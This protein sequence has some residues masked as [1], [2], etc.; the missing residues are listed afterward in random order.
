MR[1]YDKIM[2]APGK[3]VDQV[4]AGSF[5][6]IAKEMKD[7]QCFIIEPDLAV[8]CEEVC[9][10][11]PSS[12]LSALSHTRVP[13]PKTWLEWQPINR[14]LLSHQNDKPTP[15]R[16][17][18][19]IM[20]D[21]QGSRGT[22]MYFWEHSFKDELPE[23]ID[24]SS[25]LTLDPF[26]IIFDWSGTTKEPVMAQ[27]ARSIGIEIAETVWRDKYGGKGRESY[28]SSLQ[29]SRRWKNLAH[30]E[31]EVES[32]IELDKSAGIIPLIQCRPL[33]ESPIGKDLMPGGPMHDNFMEDLSGE[34][35]YTQALV[36]MLNT[37]NSVIQHTKEDLS[38]LNKARAKHRKP[39]FKEFTITN[40][41]LNKVHRKLESAAGISREVARKHLVRGHFK[42]RSSGVYWWSSHIRGI[43]DQQIKR[44]EYKVGL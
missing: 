30:Y 17:G 31:Q 35:A 18:C 42:L 23:I 2:A 6:N 41:R 16:M 1:L 27:Y 29:N 32:Y 13:Y 36:L 43:K 25:N 3:A 14:T 21:E 40:L 9:L 22:A 10:S 39:P 5:T 7:A 11:K 4:Y 33:F 38:R 26:G 8:A 15:V 34:F 20:S 28:R 12:I 24:D 19:F 37:K 44:T